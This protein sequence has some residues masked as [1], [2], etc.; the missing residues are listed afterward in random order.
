M[1][2]AG[3]EVE[4]SQSAPGGTVALFRASLDVLR[5]GMPEIGIR[6][7]GT[8]AVQN[9]LA[10]VAEIRGEMRPALEPI[11]DGETPDEAVL[12]RIAEMNGPLP[13]EMNQAVR[14]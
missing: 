11:A 3:R 14:L 2:G 7:P 4:A 10:L 12:V 1:I 6:A 13:K 5:Q 9:P 8:K